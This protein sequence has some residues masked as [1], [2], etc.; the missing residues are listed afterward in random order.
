MRQISLVNWSRTSWIAATLLACI[1]PGLGTAQSLNGFDL[2]NA[3]IPVEHILSGG[4]NRDGIPAID[5][6][7]FESAS[8]ASW[9]GPGERILGIS[10]NGISRAYP[11]AIL[12]WH[13][14]VNDVFSDRPIV[15]TYCPL[16]GTGMAFDS[17][18]DN[19]DLKFGVS[20]LLFQSDVLL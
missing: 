10:V 11:I 4:P 1:A 6:P 14:V 17:G 20:G 8:S 9:L 12:N 5:N 13:E 7:V 19:L 18:V 16:C 2:G 3:S 15:I